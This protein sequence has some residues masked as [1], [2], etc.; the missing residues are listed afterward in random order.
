MHRRIRFRLIVFSLLFCLAAVGGTGA[1]GVGKA[2]AGSFPRCGANA[3]AGGDDE[4]M[5]DDL[6]TP[7][8]KT[9]DCYG[10]QLQCSGNPSV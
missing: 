9:G 5:S 8:P 2:N 6:G 1:T 7:S 10:I 4:M 3:E